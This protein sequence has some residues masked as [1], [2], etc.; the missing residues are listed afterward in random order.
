MKYFSISSNFS[1]KNFLSHFLSNFFLN[2]FT[3]K[4]QKFT[5][6]RKNIHDLKIDSREPITTV[7][8]T[9]CTRLSIAL[10]GLRSSLI[11]LWPRGA[12]Q[13]RSQPPFPSQ[14]PTAITCSGHLFRPCHLPR[15]LRRRPPVAESTALR[16]A[17]AQ[18]PNGKRHATLR[19]RDDRPPRTHA[20][21]SHRTQYATTQTNHH[22]TN[23]W[24]LTDSTNSWLLSFPGQHA[25]ATP[26]PGSPPT[27]RSS[28]WNRAFRAGSGAPPA[29][30]DALRRRRRRPRR[31]RD[32]AARVDAPPHRGRRGGGALHLRRGGGRRALL[33]RGRRE[34]GLRGHRELRVS[35]GAGTRRAPPPHLPLF[36]PERVRP[37]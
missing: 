18:I 22:A 7:D 9:S 15:S 4:R 5:K 35:G 3:R 27:P 33:R 32:G 14:S 30:S 13:C 26:S 16:R 17:P 36:A 29:R 23:C 24:D 2:L 25:A 21:G 28:R 37:A 20:H 12:S 34:P 6:N 10:R 1:L 31:H 19:H 8:V 11:G